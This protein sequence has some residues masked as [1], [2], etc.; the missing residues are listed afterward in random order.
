MLGNNLNQ[1]D[2]FENNFTIFTSRTFG[3]NYCYTHKYPCH[4]RG[5]VLV[6]HATS[7]NSLTI[8][9]M[10]ILVSHSYHEYSPHDYCKS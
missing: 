10:N 1:F 2:M 9:I 3:R 8:M 7:T 6:F 5:F 4:H